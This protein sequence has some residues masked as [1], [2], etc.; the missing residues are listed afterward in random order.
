MSESLVAV[1][2]IIAQSLSKDRS[3]VGEEKYWLMWM[4]NKHK[5]TTEQKE[6]VLSEL[7]KP[8]VPIH[9]L[10]AQVSNKN[11]RERLLSWLHIAVNI[12]GVVHSR[13][14]CFID[15][16]TS[17]NQDLEKFLQSDTHLEMAKEIIKIEE[18]KKFWQSV[19]AVGHILQQDPYAFRRMGFSMLRWRMYYFINRLVDLI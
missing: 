16:I 3:L 17:R 14:K 10:F 8:S 18:N 5:A 2:K 11:D 12:D 9:E 7:R 4:L 19:G 1:L 15:E 6:Q 13:E